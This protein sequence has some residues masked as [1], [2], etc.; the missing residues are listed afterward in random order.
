MAGTDMAE[1]AP[2]GESAPPQGSVTPAA[3]SLN[4]YKKISVI[5]RSDDT[6]K[7]EDAEGT[8]K[9]VSIQELGDA[10]ST[11]VSEANLM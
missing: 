10:I 1:A 3:P 9:T 2:K 5:R 6:L 7:Y 11:A 8:L 4:V